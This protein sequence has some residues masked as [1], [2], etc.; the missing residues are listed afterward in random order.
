MGEEPSNDYTALQSAFTHV[1]SLASH[2]DRAQNC[3]IDGDSSTP[4][5]TSTG[6]G[7]ARG[8]TIVTCVL[9]WFRRCKDKAPS[10]GRQK[11][12]ESSR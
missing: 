2:S 8:V 9:P 3:R 1:L 5:T 11:V 12:L 6:T 7:A 10:P 4:S